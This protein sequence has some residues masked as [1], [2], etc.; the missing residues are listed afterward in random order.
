[1]G[2]YI[3][4][5]TI[6]GKNY[7]FECGMTGTAPRDWNVTCSGEQNGVAI[8]F[9]KTTN[10]WTMQQSNLTRNGEIWGMLDEYDIRRT[11]YYP[12]LPLA[13]LQDRNL[14]ASAAPQTLGAAAP[15]A[16]EDLI[17]LTDLILEAEAAYTDD[18]LEASEEEYTDDVLE[19]PEVTG[20]SNDLGDFEVSEEDLAEEFVVID[21]GISEEDF[22]EEDF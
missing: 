10:F 15:E 21:E 12:E 22:Y 3:A 16:D 2:H 1:M 17:D 4:Q 18:V 9:A 14:N 20:D 5:V 19:V 11:E 8:G 6:D 7:Y 13:I